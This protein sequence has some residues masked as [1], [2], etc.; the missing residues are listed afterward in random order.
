MTL[1]SRTWH[2]GLAVGMNAAQAHACI[3]SDR[4][5]PMLG[6]DPVRLVLDT[7]RRTGSAGAVVRYFQQQQVSW[8]RR[9]VN[10][11]EYA[12]HP[13]P[14]AAVDTRSGGLRHP[15]SKWTPERHGLVAGGAV[16]AVV[17]VA[18][19]CG[20]SSSTTQGACAS[21]M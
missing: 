9:V 21:G 16:A 4:S 6:Q 8:P 15:A 1:E 12:A 14:R 13:E 5:R 2:F 11:R 18:K 10:G 19:G 20:S 7:F 17:G 3:A